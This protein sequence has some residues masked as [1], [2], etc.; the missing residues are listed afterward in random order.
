ML[1]SLKNRTKNQFI[2][3]TLAD[4]TTLRIDSGEEVE[5]TDKQITD[6]ITTLETKGY[7]TLKQIETKTKNKKVTKATGNVVEKEVK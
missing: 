3:C 2:V 7:I 5:I 6:Y 4:N 1:Y